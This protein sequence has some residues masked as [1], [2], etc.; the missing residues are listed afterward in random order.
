GSVPLRHEFPDYPHHY[1]LTDPLNLKDIQP[2]QISGGAFLL[3]A[4]SHTRK[5]D[6]PSTKDLTCRPS[7]ARCRP[8]GTNSAYLGKVSNSARPIASG[9]FTKARPAPTVCPAFTT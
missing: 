2:R 8:G 3:H 1:Y 7:I 5:S 4:A 9:Y 6:I